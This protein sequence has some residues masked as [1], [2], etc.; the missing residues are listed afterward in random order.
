MK[1]TV[2][3]PNCNCPGSC[4]S[5][6]RHAF[7]EDC[8]LACSGGSYLTYTLVITASALGTDPLC[9]GTEQYI[10]TF[11][12]QKCP[13]GCVWESEELDEEDEPLW[14]MRGRGQTNLDSLDY[15]SIST[16]STACVPVGPP[17]TSGGGGNIGKPLIGFN[18]RVGGEF[19]INDPVDGFWLCFD[20]ATITPVG[21]LQDDCLCGNCLGCFSECNGEDE[22]HVISSQQTL[23]PFS[24]S[25]QS[26]YGSGTGTI[27]S[28]TPFCIETDLIE[29]FYFDFDD[30]IQSKEVAF[31]VCCTD[32]V[33]TAELTETSEG[34]V[35]LYA[36]VYAVHCNCHSSNN[37]YV[38]VRYC[39]ECE[40]AFP[41]ETWCGQVS[42]GCGNPVNT[43]T[44]VFP[45]PC[46][47]MGIL[48]SKAPER[49]DW[50]PI[51][52]AKGLYRAL[53]GDS[54]GVP[55][56]IPTQIPP[57]PKPCRGCGGKRVRPRGKR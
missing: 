27:V 5:E 49:R 57:K 35:P 41:F 13:Y 38:N 3:C 51:R 12:L 56:P 23:R 9:D 10:G 6:I 18:C 1:I 31:T 42:F 50:L 48:S 19:N 52:L 33:W 22:I 28:T 21:E 29:L 30:E 36:Y 43:P 8:C 45:N 20:T 55:A 24:D 39:I 16:S 46:D 14:T 40:G 15:V 7:D 25:H 53:R 4:G 44:G 2:N 54:R 34:C 11:T 37:P 32:G 47:E 26:L 17:G